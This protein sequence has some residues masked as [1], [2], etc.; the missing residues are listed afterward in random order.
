MPGMRRRQFITLLGGAVATWPL[1]ARAQGERM[2]RIGVLLSQPESDAEPQGLATLRN[3]L[4]RLGWTDGRNVRIDHRSAK[5]DPATMQGLAQELV[6]LEPDLIITQNTAT[7][8]AMLQQTHTIPIIFVVVTDPIGSGFVAS[9]ARPGG[10]ITGFITNEPPSASKWVEMLKAIA[11][12]LR[13]AAFLFNPELAPYAGEFLRHTEAA[14]GQLNVKLTPAVVR[15]EQDVE[16]ALAALSRASNGGLVVNNDGFMRVHRQQIIA[17]AARH[18]LPAI[19]PYRFFVVEGGLFHGLRCGFH[20]PA[21]ERR[22]VYDTTQPGRGNGG[23]TFG[24]RLTEAE[25]RA[26]IEYLKTL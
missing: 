25:R 3:E 1:V 2:R 4:R 6:A 10:N 24:D 26:V 11:P 20:L 7:T 17:L 15:N 19:Y 16:D 23:H 14:T 21:I 9:L 8:A 12:D 22:K 13:R 5:A 18:R